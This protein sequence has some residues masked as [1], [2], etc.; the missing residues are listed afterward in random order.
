MVV[1]P[2]APLEWELRG[3][4]QNATEFV[5]ELISQH[6][7]DLLGIHMAQHAATSWKTWKAKTT[8][9][10]RDKCSMQHRNH[11]Q[12]PNHLSSLT[13]KNFLHA[14]QTICVAS[15]V[16]DNGAAFSSL[17][18]SKFTLTCLQ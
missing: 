3:L 1:P 8:V 15:L 2:C 13:F 6:S 16:L 11:T 12:H 17:I 14:V 4:R 5:L 18:A 7:V 9:A 10:H